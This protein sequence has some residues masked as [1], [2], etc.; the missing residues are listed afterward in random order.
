MI[1]IVTYNIL[2]PLLSSKKAFPETEDKYINPEKR[3][4]KIKEKIEEWGKENAIIC[5]QELSRKWYLDIQPFLDKIAYKIIFIGYGNQYNDFMGTAI[6]YPQCYELVNAAHVCNRELCVPVKSNEKVSYFKKFILKNCPLLIKMIDYLLG[7]S[8]PQSDNEL[9]YNSWNVMLMAR[10][11]VKGSTFV[12]GNYHMPC[13]FDNR[14]SALKLLITLLMKRLTDYSLFDPHF[15]VGD[16]NSKPDSDVVNIIKSYNFTSATNEPTISSKTSKNY[17]GMPPYNE[18]K[19]QIDYIFYDKNSV[20]L[21][22]FH[23]SY[24]GDRVL[25]DEHDPSDHVP[26]SAMFEFP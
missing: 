8:V 9:I 18:F 7:I 15:F 23:S 10:F 14:Q 16:M 25:P 6:L 5:L 11:K 1:K 20:V 22:Q 19:D 26:L 13:W 12:I 3:L 17:D 24:I 4:E 21:K 2:A